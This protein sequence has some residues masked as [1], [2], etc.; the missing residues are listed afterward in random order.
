[1]NNPEWKE[2]YEKK[3]IDIEVDAFEIRFSKYWIIL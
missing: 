2:K 1:M 3:D